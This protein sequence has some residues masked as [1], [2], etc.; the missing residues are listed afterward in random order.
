M[1]IEG[2]PPYSPDLNPIENLFGILKSKLN[3]RFGTR[4]ADNLEELKIGIKAEWAKIGTDTDL[5]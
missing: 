4:G 1:E 3:N 2:Y 5:L